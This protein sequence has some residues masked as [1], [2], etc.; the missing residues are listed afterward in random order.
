MLAFLSFAG[1]LLLFFQKSK[2]ELGRSER[3]NRNILM[4]AMDGFWRTDTQGQLLE[5]NEAYCRMSG[6]SRDE[7]LGMRI[8]DLEAKEGLDEIKARTAM[9]TQRGSDRFESQHRRKDGTVFDVEISMQYSADDE[10]SH[11]VVFLRDITKSKLAEKAIRESQMRFDLAMSASKDGIFDWNLV[12]NEIYYSPGWKSMLGY[13]YDELPNDFSVWEDLTNPEDVKRSWQ[14]QQELISKQRDRFELEFRMKHKDGHWVDILSRATAVFDEDGKAVRIVGTHVDISER[15]KAE[16]EILRQ[17]GFL[18]RAQEIGKIGTWELDIKLNILLWTDEIYRIFGVPIGTNMNYEGFLKCVHPDD[19]GYVDTKWRSALNGNPYDLEHRLL[20]DGEVKWVREK[21]ELFFDEKG[22]CISGIGVTQDITEMKIAQDSLLDCE[23]RFKTLFEN[24]PMSYQSLDIDG[25]FLEVNNTWLSVMGYTR[26]EVIGRNFS[27][28]LHPEWR[29][30]FKQ[31]FPI[32]KAVGE[33]LGVEF[34]MQKKDGS[35]IL[36]SFQGKI[37]KDDKGDF[38][39]THCVFRNITDQRKAEEEKNRLESQLRQAHK[40]EALG[41]L[42]GGIAHDFNNILAAIIGYSELAVE[43]AEFGV[44]DPKPMIEVIKAGN[45]A[46]ELVTQILSF[47]RKLA[48][49]LKSIHLNEVV[50][51]TERIFERTI[52]RMVSIEHNLADEL[53]SVE[54]DA[55]QL[56]QVLINLGSNASD[57]MPDG[58]RLVIETKNVVLDDDYSRKHAGASPGQYV[59]LTVSD[60]G[61]GMDQ[62][63]LGHI[64]DP[65][66]T[67]K[68]VGKGTGMGLATVYG[69][70]KNHGGYI[71]CYSEVDQ[72]T[73]FK[74]YLPASQQEK[75]EDQ[76]VEMKVS[77]YV[78]GTETILLVDDEEDL[79]NLGKLLLARQGYQVILAESG[80]QA[81][82]IYQQ[83]GQD[84]DLVILDISMPGMGGRACLQEL[85]SSDP[86]TKVIVASGYALNGE[87]QSIAEAGANAFISKPF[88]RADLLKLVREVLDA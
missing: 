60:T 67:R 3:R 72:G 20:V 39:Q 65:F 26:E 57:A 87:T 37:A 2:N 29:D 45:R 34:E 4:T 14:M 74:V 8:S 76:P 49:T 21:A 10:G 68:E 15:T 25:N 18:E 47:S 62:E 5:V 7:L 6:Y 54:A 41:T 64:F 38:K 16:K 82:E 61:H 31:N 44:A 40:M 58:G 30:H 27:E 53:W 52:P 33:I 19:R 23:A 56:I 69:I 32:F 55:N 17:R 75:I 28:F 12:T 46:K 86:A 24:A 1:I 85:K 9:L 66:F 73:T 78:G 70:V 50:E 81:L 63:T 48:P 79:R 36:V 43:D 59:L 13:E 11:G 84:I 22:D 35:L 83:Q 80:E 77:G 42:A 51:E 71:M 88:S